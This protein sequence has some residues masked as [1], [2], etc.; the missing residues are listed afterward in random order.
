[1]LILLSYTAFGVGEWQ[2]RLPTA[3]G[4]ALSVWVLFRIIQRASGRG[5]GL[6]AAALFAIAPMTL[7]FGGMP[8]VVGQPLVLG[9]LLTIRSY[10]RYLRQPG[11]RAMGRL[12]AAFALAGVSDWPGFMTAQRRAAAI[13]LSAEESSTAP[14]QGG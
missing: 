8:E 1:L 6:T 13:S 14:G 11:P 4:T 3:L 10:L 5:A 12:V 7:Y 9:A 2:A